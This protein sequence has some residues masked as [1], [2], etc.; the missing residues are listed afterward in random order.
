MA[1]VGEAVGNFADFIGN[2]AE[3][4]TGADDVKAENYAAQEETKRQADAAQKLA[5]E[6]AGNI[7]GAYNQAAG[8]QT[9]A[10]NQAVGMLNPYAQQGA[11]FMGQY[12]DSLQNGPNNQYRDQMLGIMNQGPS[13]M[14]TQANNQIMQ[15]QSLSPE[16]Q[17]MMSSPLEVGAIEDSRGYGAMVKARGEA[18]DAMTTGAGAT[19]MMFSGARAKGLS[20]IS[21]R[22][23]Q[24]LEEQSYNRAANE[25]QNNISNRFQ[26]ERENY[27]RG[28]NQISQMLGIDQRDYNREQNRF[29]QFGGFESQD[30]N[31]NQAYMDRL[32][33]MGAMGLDVSGQLANMSNQYGQNMGANQVNSAL[34][35]ANIL[36]G[37]NADYANLMANA[38]QYGIQGAKTRMD[39]LSDVIGAGAKIYGASQGG[40]AA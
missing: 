39:A 16:L 27:G 34:T 17:E 32:K 14:A 38:T 3:K 25:R 31:K 18:M 21:G 23:M 33:N 5:Q 19:G 1:L 7:G 24:Q 20:D 13:Q 28:Q 9:N 2:T 15:D 22:E 36:Q 8:M 11:Q 40:G 4:L 37:G 6:Q 30:Y 12:Q 26:L 10:Y 29:N 35:Q